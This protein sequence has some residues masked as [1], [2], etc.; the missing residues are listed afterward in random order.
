MDPAAELSGLAV[1]LIVGLTGVGGVGGVGGGSLMTPLLM[2]VN[3]LSLLAPS[4]PIFGSRPSPSRADAGPTIASAMSSGYFSA[5]CWS[6]RFQA[7]GW[8]RG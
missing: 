2:G 1:G 7:S 4:A 8:A 5:R 3:K 6:A